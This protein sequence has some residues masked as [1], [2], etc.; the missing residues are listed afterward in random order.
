MEVGAVIVNRVNLLVVD[1]NKG[2]C[3]GKPDRIRMVGWGAEEKVGVIFE[4][5][6]V[7]AAGD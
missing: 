3:L 5:V 2:V 6:D 7:V 4:V 1:K